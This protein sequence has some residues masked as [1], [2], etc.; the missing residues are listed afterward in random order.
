MDSAFIR[1]YFPL[2][3][4]GSENSDDFLELLRI[5]LTEPMKKTL[6]HI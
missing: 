2:D 6:L 5:Y 4:F 1:D 3:V